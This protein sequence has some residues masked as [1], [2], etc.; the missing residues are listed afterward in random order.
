M[1][2]CIRSADHFRLL[3]NMSW[4]RKETEKVDRVIAPSF[5][6]KSE[7]ARNGIEENKVELIPHFTEK[8]ITGE[9]NE[10]EGSNI[11]FIGRAD[12]L[13]GLGVLLEALILIRNDSW[14]A[15]IICSGEGAEDYRNLVRSLGLEGRILFHGGVDYADLDDYYKKASLVVF[16]SVSVESFGLVGIEAM[17]FGKP[18]VAFDVGGPREWLLHGETGYLVERGNAKELARA[19]NVILKD[20]PLANQMGRKAMNRVN[21]LFRKEGHVEKVFKVYESVIKERTGIKGT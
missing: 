15:H 19:I 11:L 7:A 16:P 5:Y 13:K 18:V 2:G 4:R 17:S 3:L 10:G 21:H 20:P 14:T 9:W 8:N 12:P 1:S 6:I